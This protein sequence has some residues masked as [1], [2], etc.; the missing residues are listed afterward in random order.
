M[1]VP[2]ERVDGASNAGAVNVLYG[3][4]SGLS[5]TGN[6]LWSQ[7]SPDVLDAAEA[8]DG[9]GSVLAMGD[10]NGDGSD[11]L[12]VGVVNEKLGTVWWCRRGQRSLREMSAGC[13]R[14]ETSSGTR[15]APAS[16]TPPSRS[17]AS[18]LPLPRA[19]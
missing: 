17:T 16:S 2:I 5:A 14:P 9:F 8:H 4:A 3:G 12:A 18:G 1:G 7:N 11:D 13:R 15:T 19:T 10:F 6:Q